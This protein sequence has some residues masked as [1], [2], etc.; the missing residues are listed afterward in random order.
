MAGTSA[1]QGP[2]LLWA[3]KTLSVPSQTNPSVSIKRLRKYRLVYAGVQR[4]GAARGPPDFP[5]LAGRQQPRYEWWRLLKSAQS[6]C[7]CAYCVGVPSCRGPAHDCRPLS[8]SQNGYVVK[9]WPLRAAA[10]ALT[11]G[12]ARP[13]GRGLPRCAG[14]LRL[15]VG[16]RGSPRAEVGQ[17]GQRPGHTC[18]GLLASNCAG[19]PAPP[20]RRQPP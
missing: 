11:G 13:P 4:D 8:Q 18:W 14:E 3:P 15:Q 7:C 16:V 20:L 1:N 17:H 19:S 6:H 9:T 2:D 5:P 12:G 10:S